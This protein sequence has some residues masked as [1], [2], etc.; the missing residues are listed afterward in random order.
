MQK[1][2]AEGDGEVWYQPYSLHSEPRR[3]GIRYL[4][5]KYVKCVLAPDKKEYMEM[6]RRRPGEEEARERQRRGKE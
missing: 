1:A 5:Y 2:S 6:R 4:H 3:S